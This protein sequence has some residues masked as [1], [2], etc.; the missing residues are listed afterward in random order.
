[1][2]EETTRVEPLPKTSSV[3][4]ARVF[5]MPESYRHGKES[6]LVEPKK[7]SIHPVVPTPPPPVQKKPVVPLK[8]PVPKKHTYRALIIAGVCILLAL[9]IGGYV[10]IRRAQQ[11][12]LVPE[13]PV[14]PSQPV[15]QQP[16]VGQPVTPEPESTTPP[17]TQNPFQTEVTSGKDADSDGL[18][19]VEENLI[20]QTNPNLPDSDAD[21]FLDGNEVFHRYNPN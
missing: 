5:T 13:T 9:G 3:L 7:E 18:T 17:E 15:V 6:K 2:E 20:Y 8:Q 21:G 4:N 12:P 19:D 14:V 1:M 10:L 11:Q 16:V